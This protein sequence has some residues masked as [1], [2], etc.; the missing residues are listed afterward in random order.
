MYNY[1]TKLVSGI[2]A[3]IV[4]SFTACQKQPVGKRIVMEGS[5]TVLPI[6][7]K[8]AE[9]FMKLH[10][11]VEISVRGGGSGV[12]ITSLI[13]GTCDI[14]NSSRAMEPVEIEKAQT[15][16]KKPISHIVAID[17]I[18]VIVHP[19]NKVGNL[20]KKQLR[21]IYT[22]KLSDWSEVGGS[23]QKIVV[24][25][26]DSA[27]G[28]FEAFGKLALGE[29]K[30]RPDALMQASNKVVA[31]VVATT[32]GAIG[33][34][35]LGYVSSKV[36]LLAVDMIRADR[37]NIAS[38]KYLLARELYM[39]TDGEPKGVVKDFIDF[40]LSPEGQKLVEEEGYVTVR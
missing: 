1:Y 33:Y 15:K 19:S 6:A 22:G 39:Y 7:Q 11:E 35:G 18:A 29:K 5:T 23:K 28:T 32:P 3:V 20:T 24:I 25:S 13:E 4:F 9:M 38:G 2:L 40:V 36:K 31:G 30:V 34:I 16:G 8:T 21:D 37:K 10:P 14:A 12:G 26:R 27:S 17:G